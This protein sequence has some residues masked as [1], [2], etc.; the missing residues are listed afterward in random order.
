MLHSSTYSLAKAVS[1]YTSG[2]YGKV[3]GYLNRELWS[4]RAQG[5]AQ[6]LELGYAGHAEVQLM[7]Y[8]LFHHTALYENVVFIDDEVREF[9]EK[10]GEA[11]SVSS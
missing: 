7:A 6:E 1:G 2:K 11:G 8:L 4:A 10:L 5:F 9:R 3:D